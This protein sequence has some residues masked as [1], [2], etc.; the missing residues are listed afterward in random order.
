MILKWR[1]S[2]LCWCENLSLHNHTSVNNLERENIGGYE[3]CSHLFENEVLNFVV[4]YL[5]TLYAISM[6][7]LPSLLFPYKQ[8][9]ETLRSALNSED[10]VIFNSDKDWFSWKRWE[11]NEKRKKQKEAKSQDIYVEEEDWLYIDEHCLY[12]TMCG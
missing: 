12:I 2:F 5:H 9:T 7:Y 3:V 8:N 1:V 6:L 10:V 4:C 11:I